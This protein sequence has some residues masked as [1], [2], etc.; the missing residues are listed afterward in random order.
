MRVQP[1]RLRVHTSKHALK[2]EAE[3][4]HEE[5]GG[6]TTQQNA[7]KMYH[8]EQNDLHGMRQL[9]HYF[10]TYLGSQTN[11]TQMQ[12]NTNTAM[13]SAQKIPHHVGQDTSV[14]V[15]RDFNAGV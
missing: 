9:Q 4:Q 5:V 3:R 2:L 7:L 11:R 14:L 10:G 8:R 12:T 1:N 15:V 6:S 13:Q